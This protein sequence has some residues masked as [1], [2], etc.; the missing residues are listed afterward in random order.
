MLDNPLESVTIDDDSLVRSHPYRFAR[1]NGYAIAPRVPVGQMREL[2]PLSDAFMVGSDQLWNYD[3]SRPYEE[4]YYLAF[5]DDSK[6]RIAYGT[7]FGAPTF[8]GPPEY[9]GTVRYQLARFGTLMVRDP[10]SQAICRQQ[11]DLPAH[12]V[13]DP[14]FLC[15]RSQFDSL[16]ERPANVPDEFLL[17]YVLDPTPAHG[18]HIRRLALNNGLPVVVILDELDSKSANNRKKLGLSNDPQVTIIDQATAGE[19]IWCFDHA[20]FVV[21]DSFHG[22]CFSIVYQRDF[23]ALKHPWRAPFRFQQLLEP[24]GL[25]SRLLTGPSDLDGRDLESINYAPVMRELQSHSADSIS[26]LKDALE[27]PLTVAVAEPLVPYDAGRLTTV[28]MIAQHLATQHATEPGWRRAKGVR[29]PY[30][31]ATLA[32][33]PLCSGCLAC[34]DACPFDALQAGTDK[35]GL[36][37][38]QL[39]PSRCTDCGLCVRICPAI[40]APAKPTTHPLACYSFQTDDED[41]LMSSSSGGVFGLLAHQTIVDGGAVAGAAWGEDLEVRHMVITDTADLPRLHKSKYCQSNTTGVFRD[42]RQRLR[43]G[44]RVLFSGLPC[45]VAGLRGFLKGNPENLLAVDLLCGNAPPPAMF[46]AYVRETWPDGV[47]DFEFR[48][49]EANADDPYLSRITLADGKQVVRPRDGDV[50][51]KA[52]HAHD[53][54]PLHCENCRY[55]AAPRYGDITIGDFWGLEKH[56]PTP[57]TKNGMSVVL[58]NSQRGA[59]FLSRA[60]GPEVNQL[61]NRPIEWLGGNGFVANGAHGWASLDRDTFFAAWAAARSFTRAAAAPAILRE[62][63]GSLASNNATP[64]PSN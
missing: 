16:A 13:T 24:L 29:T 53:L 50:Y 26:K 27:G 39:V 12:Q 43:D 21:T 33:N 57:H 44:Q 8:N 40:V 32:M 20:R 22:C 64:Q 5:T 54:C 46:Q 37:R 25:S 48:H 49:K 9:R 51:Q 1:R 58:V 36:L 52:Y 47:R 19:L 17:A 41:L 38:P 28:P 59:D 55:Q 34:V 23:W 60:L 3:L 4:S 45:Q 63:A 7:S 31:P 62:V 14:V 10:E 18:Q 42:V 11:F 15:E 35:Y 30:V 2:N 56:D 61:V 6:R